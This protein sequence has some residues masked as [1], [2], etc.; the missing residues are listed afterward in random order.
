MARKKIKPVLY[1]ELSEYASLIRALRANHTLDLVPHLAQ[2]PATNTIAANSLPILEEKEALRDGEM[3][4]RKRKRG[5]SA[6]S[7]IGKGKQKEKMIWTRWPLIEGDVFVPEWGLGDEVKLLAKECLRSY[8]NLPHEQ[9]AYMEVGTNES[10]L[11]PTIHPS[12]P[13]PSPTD[14]DSTSKQPVQPFRHHTSTLI[15][16]SF[17]TLPSHALLEHTFALLASHWPKTENSLRNRLRPFG[18]ETVLEIL[19]ASGVIEPRSVY[20]SHTPVLH[21]LIL[22]RC[23]NCPS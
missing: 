22:F 10:E 15:R 21:A 19:S 9:A 7:G 1:S 17:L 6:E 23:R 18:W 8:S 5:T 16:N 11:E 20:N 3:R 13:T 4:R 12:S 14:P 2:P